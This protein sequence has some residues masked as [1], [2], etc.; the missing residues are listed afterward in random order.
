MSGAR[1]RTTE[2]C[3]ALQNT[4]QATVTV[5]APWRIDTSTNHIP[6]DAEGGALSRILKYVKLMYLLKR[7]QNSYIVSENPIAPLPFR[8]NKIF[9][10]IHDAKFAT[11]AGRPGKNLALKVHRISSRICHH[12]VTVSEAEKNRLSKVLE[13]DSKKIFV[14]KNGLSEEWF[15]KSENRATEYDILYVSN[16]APHKNHLNLLKSCVGTEWRIAFVGS[17]MGTLQSCKDYVSEN[18]L[19]CT[20]LS[21]L[22]DSELIDIYDASRI[23]V[24]PSTLEGFGIPFIEARARGLPV[25]ANDIEVFQS[26]ALSLQGTVVNF[27]RPADVKGAIESTLQ[28]S[29]NVPDTIFDYRWGKIA[30][31]FIAAARQSPVRQL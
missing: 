18:K 20:F 6:F 23:F 15:R 22:S 5:L 12:V 28:S 2:L 19:R 25:L 14:S 24:F 27:E 9:H 11:D 21:K 1:R 26:L 17:D 10:V 16:F 29:K 7:F 30:E 4:G 3:K 13:L 31:D 8:S